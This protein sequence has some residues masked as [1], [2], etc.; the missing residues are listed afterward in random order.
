[1]CRP[2]ARRGA[3]CMCAGNDGAHPLGAPV[4]LFRGRSHPCAHR[5]LRARGR[6]AFARLLAQSRSAHRFARSPGRQTS[7]RRQKT[8]R[9]YGVS[10]SHIRISMSR[11]MRATSR[12]LGSSSPFR[13]RQARRLSPFPHG[14]LA[15]LLCGRLRRRSK[16]RR[17]II[18]VPTVRR[19]SLTKPRRSIWRSAP[20]SPP[21]WRSLLS[22]A[23]AP[24]RHSSNGRR[25]YSQRSRVKSRRG[26]ALV[27]R[28]FA[29]AIQSVHRALDRANGAILL[30]GDLPEF[31]RRRP[32]FKPLRVD[33]E[34]FFET[35]KRLFF[36][37]ESSKDDYAAE[38]LAQFVSRLARQERAG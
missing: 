13:R 2:H 24:G 21:C 32:E 28:N 25:E 37:G 22:R 20:A 12:F 29:A 6:R 23:I 10:T 27:T 35:S 1:M 17:R 18:C 31:L 5:R 7:A 11:S 9:A 30:S 16:S 36:G 8:A 15:F 33:F 19:H 4:R 38:Q 26:A 14:G 3:S 34:R